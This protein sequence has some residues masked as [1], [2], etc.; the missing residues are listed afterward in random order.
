MIEEGFSPSNF[1]ELKEELRTHPKET[2]SLEKKLEELMARII[3]A[4]KVIN[5]MK[6]MKTMTREIRDKCTSF[7]NRLVELEKSISD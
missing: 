1:S 5:E 4:E 2:K 7:G 3:N 6:E